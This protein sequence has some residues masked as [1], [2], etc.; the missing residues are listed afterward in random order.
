MMSVLRTKGK[1]QQDARERRDMTIA[2]P[3]KGDSIADH[4][5]QCDGFLIYQTWD[6]MVAN[7][8]T[9]ETPL[10]DSASFV[11]ALPKITIVASI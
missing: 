3:V 8:E 1:S 5:C 2:V 11:R 9:I 4:F 6:K 7:M 10:A